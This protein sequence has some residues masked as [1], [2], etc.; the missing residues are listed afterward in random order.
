[1]FRFVDPMKEFLRFLSL[2]ASDD[3]GVPSAS[4]VI[5]AVIFT[6]LGVSLAAITAV[7]LWKIVVTTDQVNLSTVVGALSKSMWIY[8]ILA[9]TALS[10]Y[11]I[12]IWKYIAQIRAGGVIND[13]MQ[14]GMYNPMNPYN[15][16]N[17]YNRLP[18]TPM[19]GNGISPMQPQM[20]MVPTVMPQIPTVIS[21]M[22][23]L[24]QGGSPGTQ[25]VR[26]EPGRLMETHTDPIPPKIRTVEPGVGS[27]D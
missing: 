21:Q 13:Q 16:M 5:G 1:M 17:T 6:I 3:R 23:Q 20:P 26:T 11:G 18:Q 7:L 27:D 12:N 8:M 25:I 19:T 15:Q 4:R 22:P 10:L 14:S 24:G 9:A 2:M